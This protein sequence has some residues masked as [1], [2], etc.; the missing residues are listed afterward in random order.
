MFDHLPE[1]VQITEV[2]PRDGLQNEPEFVPTEIKAEFIRRLAAAGLKRIEITSFVNPKWIP[3]LRDCAEVGRQFSRME[4]VET[5]ALVPNLKGLEGADEAGMREI[6]LFLSA[7]E[8]HNKANI[9]KDI[10]ETLR[11]FAELIPEAKRRGMRVTAGI[12][13]AFGCPYE[14]DVD[15]ERV[16]AIARELLDSGVDRL[17]LGDT[18]GVANPLQVKRLLERLY[19][20]VEPDLV[21]LHFHD[22]Q[23]TAVANA[24]AALEMGITRFDGSVGGLGGCPY[25][26][27]ASG[28]VPTENLVY[29]F[30]EMGVDTG[31]DLDMLLEVGAY[32][33]EQLGHPLPSSGL[34]AYL[35]RK[36]KAAQKAAEKSAEKVAAA[37]TAPAGA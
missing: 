22:T 12:S 16:I 25:A 11:Q 6:V 18:I 9:N 8:S 5:T 30:R 15:P 13:T 2:G 14:G 34:R 37:A 17:F 24:V 36:V 29:T 10:A 27:G 21:S 23:G 28:N 1:R 26:P 32:I 31:I 35:G 20:L 19:A 7:T 3:P 33:Q 4:G